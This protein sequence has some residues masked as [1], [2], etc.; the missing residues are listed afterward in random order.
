MVLCLVSFTISVL[1]IFYSRALSLVDQLVG[2][3]LAP[4][5]WKAAAGII[6][7]RPQADEA[8]AEPNAYEEPTYGT[9]SQ[10]SGR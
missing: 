6:L 8:F 9:D 10:A 4:I 2:L 5:H 7:T 3:P 1:L